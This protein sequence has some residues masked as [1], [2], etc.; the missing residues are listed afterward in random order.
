MSLACSPFL[1]SISAM[2]LNKGLSLTAL[3][4]FCSLCLQHK[5]NH[6]QS[7]LKKSLPLL[8]WSMHPTTDDMAND[9][10]LKVLQMK[11]EQVEMEV[12][13]AE[14][15]EEMDMNDNTRVSAHWGENLANKVGQ[16]LVDN[17][18]NVLKVLVK[19]A[20]KEFSFA[21]HDMYNGVLHLPKTREEHATA[22]S[23][24]NYVGL[25]NLVELFNDL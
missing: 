4:L 16:A 19:N 10:V 15:C 1:P 24:L 21:P 14:D 5:Y 2:S 9:A 25:K 18:D 17:V 23:S 20:T 7:R 8:D 12:G 13:Q 6:F 11:R 3:C 22:I